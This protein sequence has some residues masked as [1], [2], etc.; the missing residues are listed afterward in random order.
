MEHMSNTY[1]EHVRGRAY[2]SK[3]GLTAMFGIVDRQPRH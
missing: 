3:P 2:P 1:A